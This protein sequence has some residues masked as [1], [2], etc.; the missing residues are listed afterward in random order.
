MAKIKNNLQQKVEN[1][2]HAGCWC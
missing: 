2:Q 1:A